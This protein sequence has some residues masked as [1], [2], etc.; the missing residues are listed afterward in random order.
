M[1]WNPAG[2]ITLTF[3]AVTLIMS[4]FNSIRALLSKEYKKSQQRKIADENIDR[5]IDG[6]NGVMTSSHNMIMESVKAR[7]DEIKTGFKSAVCQIALVN[8]KMIDLT[9]D[10]NRISADIDKF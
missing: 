6:M 3:G 4:F 2:W 5:F 8:S 1:L 9:A 10:L 7:I